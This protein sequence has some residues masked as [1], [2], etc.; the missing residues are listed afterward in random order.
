MTARLIVLAGLPS[1]EKAF[2]AAEL[3]A[4]W[5]QQGLSVAILDNIARI[6]ID[7]ETVGRARVT[8]AAGDMLPHLPYLLTQ[9]PAD[10]VIFAA[11]ETLPTDAL[12]AALDSLDGVR[13]TVA[14]LI[15]TRTCDCFPH[16]RAQLEADADTVIHIPYDLRA[17]VAALT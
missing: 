1:I 15:D 17:V 13:V 4:F 3:G 6:A 11:S 16:M 5:A 10:R 2:L 7:P 8:R 12:F 9:T 14:G